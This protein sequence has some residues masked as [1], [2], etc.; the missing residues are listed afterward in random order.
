MA[1][2]RARAR[3]C[4][5]HMKTKLYAT[6]SFIVEPQ[7]VAHPPHSHRGSTQRVVRGPTLCTHGVDAPR[8]PL[9]PSSV[10]LSSCG[11]SGALAICASCYH[12]N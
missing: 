7:Y 2:P 3:G 6:Y 5:C 11:N 12:H 1:A 8:G 10:L 4:T 9:P